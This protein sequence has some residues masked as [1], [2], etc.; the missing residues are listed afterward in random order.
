MRLREQ[1]PS[2]EA[3]PKVAERYV[4]IDFDRCLGNT[5]A[6]QRLLEEVVAHHSFITPDD[7]QQARR[8]VEETGG[9]FDTASWVRERLVEAGKHGQWNDIAVEMVDQAQQR[10]RDTFLMPGAS[11]LLD[12]LE[13]AATPHGIL[14]YGGE[15]W[16]TIKLQA[17]GLAFV[18]Q[19]IVS[20]KA[21]GRLIA[22]WQTPGGFLLP[23]E[24]SSDD[25][26]LIARHLI[27]IDDKAVS[28]EGAPVCENLELL[29]VTPVSE[30][31]SNVTS[32]FA[33][34][35]QVDDHLRR[36]ARYD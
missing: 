3:E 9:S 16:Q 6:L 7:M 34:M 24:L 4:L 26:P 20:T 33:S 29:H 25:Q 12:Q 14:T 10:G 13:Q 1:L 8:M 28:F 32:R 5:D 15:T 11:E 31:A 22:S 17:A 21:K 30:S 19:M 18:P 35:A 23:P 2:R 27:F 36:R